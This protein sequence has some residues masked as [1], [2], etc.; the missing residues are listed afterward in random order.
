VTCAAAVVASLPANSPDGVE[1]ECCASRD[2]QAHGTGRLHPCISH[3]NHDSLRSAHSIWCAASHHACSPRQR[4]ASG[5]NPTVRIQSGHLPIPSL[6]PILPMPSVL[7]DVAT[8]P[9]LAASFVCVTTD[10]KHQGDLAVSPADPS[11][12]RRD[13]AAQ[14]IPWDPSDTKGTEHSCAPWTKQEAPWASSDAY[15]VTMGTSAFALLPGPVTP[16]SR[17]LRCLGVCTGGK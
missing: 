13:L 17:G 11:H 5:A 8:A 6:Q 15:R 3:A 7:D 2:V 9:G 10:G 1:R 12:Y 16:L 14:D 4:S